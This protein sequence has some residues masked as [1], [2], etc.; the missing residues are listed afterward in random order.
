MPDNL[1]AYEQ[2]STDW[3][4]ST[5]RN[6]HRTYITIGT[7][8]LIYGCLGLLIDTYM[9]SSAYPGIP[10]NIIVKHLLSLEPFPIAT[11]ILLI[12]AAMALWATFSF[13]NRLMLLGTEA[14]EI[15]PETA[16]NLEEQQL[17]NIIDELR[18][19]AG[20]KFMPKVFIINANYMNA[21]A[22][23]YSEKS[24]MVA[25][26]SGLLRKLDRA[27]TQAVMAHEISHIRNMDIK[28][29]L[30]ASVLANI[31][32][33]T[34]D[35][36]FYAMIFGNRNREKGDNRLL[37][38]ITI[39]RYT[40]PLVTILLTLYLSRTREYM[41]DAGCVEITRDNQPLAR[42]LLKIQADTQNNAEE[43]AREYA[44]TPHE[45]V[46]RAAYIFDPRKAGISA[47]SFSDL[48]STHPPLEKRLAAIG[49]KKR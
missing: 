9:L 45:E 32:L 11:L 1:H 28:L 33:I 23:G 36:F 8:F 46:R 3:R 14:R 40:L 7:F 21:F 49:F 31:I 2:H 38:V 41:A 13:H 29:T 15:K 24:S 47:Q 19:A 42:A 10:V 43:Q 27:E 6:T 39:L 20:L 44:K 25:I 35:Y 26:T 34:L 22:S 48:F 16:N 17:Y 30:M 18:I 12:I 37:L 4:A 5:R